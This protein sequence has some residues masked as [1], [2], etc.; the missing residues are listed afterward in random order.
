MEEPLETQPTPSRR[1]ARAPDALRPL[2]LQTAVLMHPEGSA[3][4]AF[5]HTRVLCTASVETTVPAF[6]E[7]QGHGWVTAEYAMLPRATDTRGRR[8]PSGRSREISRL[9]GRVLRQAVDLEALQGYVVTVDCDVLQAD[10]GT[11]TAAITGGYVALAQALTRLERAGSLPGSALREPV[12][13][14]SVG[15]VDGEPLLDLEY[16]EDHRAEVDLN[17]AMT[18]SGQLVEIQGTAERATFSRPQLERLLDLAQKG[19]DELV[20]RQANALETGA[21]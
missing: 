20:T 6:A 10:G 21:P 14:V 13:A 12:A 16:E 9:V 1:T 4:I 5:G 8:K 18:A 15:L 19:I 11:R 3:E 7:S 17:V 2:S